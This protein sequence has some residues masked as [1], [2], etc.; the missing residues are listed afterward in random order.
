MATY[1]HQSEQWPHFTWD[2]ELV[3]DKLATVNKASG[4]LMGRLNAI[5]FDAQMSA[6]AEMLSNDIINSSEIEGISLNVKQV[7]SSIARKLG[8]PSDADEPSSHYVEGI[9]EM[10]LDAVSHYRQPL[11]HERLFGW[12]NCMFPS[13]MSG[14][15]RIDVAQYRKG[16]MKVVSGNY[17]REKIHYE[18]V[19]AQDVPKEM[20]LFL[21]WFNTDCTAPTYLK[22]AIAH[23]WFVCIHPFDDGNGRIGRAI[24]DMALSQADDSA[25][26]FFSMSRQINKDKRSYYNVLEHVSRQTDVDIT[27]WLIWYLDCMARAIHAS[28]EVL[29]RI[30]QK[31]A[32]WQ[33]H[34]H[35]AFTERQNKVLNIYLD[36]YIGKLTVKN[37]AKHCKVSA[38]TASR[39]IKDLVSKGVL[40][41]QQGRMRDVFYGIRCDDE[42]LLI[43]GPQEDED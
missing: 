28:D 43:P 27:E 4:F 35:V 6:S 39:D 16:E 22:S 18:A 31:A 14:Y 23:F 41:P 19:P 1:I 7:R 32:F 29:S 34:A 3:A 33:N 40:E 25:M 21:D 37:W 17:G 42:T 8:I 38:D 13:G 5:G 9:V 26:R 30:L 36:G 15:S 24:A 10:M 12:H 20:D 11:T 2:K